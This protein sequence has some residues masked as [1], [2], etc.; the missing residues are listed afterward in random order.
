MSAVYRV[1][2]QYDAVTPSDVVLAKRYNQFYDNVHI[3]FMAI[4]FGHAVAFFFIGIWACCVPSS[5]GG[6]DNPQF[7]LT[8]EEI[9]GVTG[10]LTPS[11]HKA[12]SV[13]YPWVVI[14]GCMVGG[15]FWILG[16]QLGGSARAFLRAKYH[17]RQI[18]IMQWCDMGVSGAFFFGLLLNMLTVQNYWLIT[19][20]CI[21]YISSKGL[22][23][24]QEFVFY[25]EGFDFPVFH[26]ASWLLH[27]ALWIFELA[28]G[29]NNFVD[30]PTANKIAFWVWFATDILILFVSLFDYT[31][32]SKSCHSCRCIPDYM[33]SGDNC[34]Y[35]LYPLL[36]LAG[37]LTVAWCLFGSAYIYS[38]LQ[39]YIT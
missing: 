18:R 17:Y 5:T 12:G 9:S 4:L 37:R 31:N 36:S 13:H 33:K 24:A 20:A 21:T 2:N 28:T 7:I 15:A 32:H 16:W 39:I 26:I 8:T 14:A 6:L 23:L 1:V 3:A 11:I 35:L 30:I 29:F 27:A 34:A 25:N 10:V 19:F 22:L 38:F